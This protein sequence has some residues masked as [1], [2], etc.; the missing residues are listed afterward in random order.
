MRQLCDPNNA[1]T[2]RTTGVVRAAI[3]EFWNDLKRAHYIDLATRDLELGPQRRRRLM[4][5]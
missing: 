3:E 5:G 2:G 1:T 4:R